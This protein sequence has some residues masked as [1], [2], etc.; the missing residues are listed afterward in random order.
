MAA[1]FQITLA[2]RADEAALR[3]R[4]AEDHM[5]GNIVLSFRREPDYFLGCSVQGDQ[6]QIIK[7]T[8][9][10]SGRIVGLGAR[11]TTRLFINGFEVRVG[12]LSDLR[13]D[14]AVRHRTLLARGYSFLRELHDANPLPLYF[15]IILDGNNDAISSLT[16]AR[17]GLPIYEDRGRILT[18]AIHLDR[19]RPEQV[20]KGVTMRR[21]TA[22]IMSHVFTFLRKENA[23]K[24]FAPCYQDR[25]FGSSRLLGLKPEDF[26]VAY[27]GDRIIGCVATWDQ[28][29]FRQT[30]VERYSVPLRMARPFYNA[31]ARLSSLHALPAPG[32]KIPYLYL[33]LIAT[34]NNCPEI[35]AT[36]LRVVYRDQRR[37]KYQFLIAGLHESDPLCSVLD[38]YRRIEAGGRL[39]V[40]YYPED[41]GFITNLDGRTPYVEMA[42]V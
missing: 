31:A 37:S 35:F 3:C 16:S 28:S 23:K 38:D 5:Q 14:Q 18:P 36:L 25:D 29:G 24:Q 1:Q 7:C 12:Y 42:T 10:K 21:G 32:E 27:R 41:A 6:S 20:C 40:I 22:L 9:S 2:D 34:E 19:H 11:H 17:A 30:H 13:T 4:M 39:F 8:D 26:Y 15:S 33:S